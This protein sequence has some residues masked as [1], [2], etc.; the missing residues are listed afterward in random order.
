MNPN[1][2]SFVVDA[3]DAGELSDLKVKRRNDRDFEK[4]IFE[5]VGFGGRSNEEIADAFEEEKG[6]K[7]KKKK[8]SNF[9]NH[10]QIFDITI[11]E[12]KKLYEELINSPRYYVTKWESHFS[13]VTSKYVIVSHYLEDL[14]SEK[15]A[16]IIP[17]D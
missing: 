5:K 15:P 17:E 2:E 8:F 1:T 14:D 10:V 7:Q 3:Y 11:P 13:N 12:E 4:E 16:L 6:I 9:K